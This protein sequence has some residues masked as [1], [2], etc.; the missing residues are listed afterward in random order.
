MKF[1]DIEWHD[2]ILS[3]LT[4][5]RTNPG[6]NDSIEL[7]IVVNGNR[8][9]VLFENVYSAD[10]RMNFGVI[11]EESIRYAILNTDDVA[12]PNI[13]KMWRNVGVDLDK[14]FCFELSTNSTNSL[15][16]IYAISY[17]IKEHL[18]A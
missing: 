13:Q 18:T 11:A 15:I 9:I 1:E 16:K 6:N 7:R 14:L 12:M 5:D 3:S 8:M 17:K 10:L 2:Q 4:M